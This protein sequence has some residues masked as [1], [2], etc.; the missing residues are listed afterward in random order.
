[1]G[2]TLSRFTIAK[3]K[4]VMGKNKM[5]LIFKQKNGNSVKIEAHNE[6]YV[7]PRKP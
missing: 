3:L 1:M 7:D 6:E 2:T 5:W 4:L